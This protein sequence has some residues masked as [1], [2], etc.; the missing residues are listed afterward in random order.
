MGLFMALSGSQRPH[1]RAPHSGLQCSNYIT[2]Q[3]EGPVCSNGSGYFVATRVCCTFP[4]F[5]IVIFAEGLGRVGDVSGI[6]SHRKY[7]QVV[8]VLSLSRPWILPDTLCS[9]PFILT[10]FSSLRP[11]PGLSPGSLPFDSPLIPAEWLLL[12]CL[13][14]KSDEFFFI[15]SSAYVSDT[16]PCSLPTG[17]CCSECGYSDQY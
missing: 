4:R 6:C 3:K 11:R 2:Q 15:I 13:S 14:F 7:V 5:I 10:C 9:L 8:C 17:S 12:V 16:V 1:P